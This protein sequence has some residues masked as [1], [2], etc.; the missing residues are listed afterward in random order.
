MNR[1]AIDVVFTWVDSNHP[2]WREEKDYWEKKLLPESGTSKIMESRLYSSFDEIRYGLRSV[3]GYLPWVRHIFLVTNNGSHPQWLN[4][5]DPKITVVD[6][7]T[8][9]PADSLPNYN[10]NAI[11]A[12]LY[13]IPGLSEHFVYFN[14]DLLL[15]KPLQPGHF[16]DL[17]NN[18]LIYPLES[19]FLFKI[20]QRNKF[21]TYL[22][23]KYLK[24]DS[25]VIRPRF[26]TMKE[27]DIPYDGLSTAHCPKILSKSQ[28]RM[29]NRS[30]P[31]QIEQLL[32]TK[33][34]TPT[35]FTYLEA[36]FHYSVKKQET[37]QFT[38]DY[39][40][41]IITILD[42]AIPNSIQIRRTR[43]NLKKYTFL[44]V[45]NAR[46]RI[47]LKEE[48]KFASFLKSLFPSPAPW[49]N[50]PPSPL[51]FAPGQTDFGVTDVIS[52]I[53]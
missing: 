42:Y 51:L 16:I 13:R 28:C 47:N 34:R 53:Q 43:R 44:A 6:Y 45:E 8:L 11:E 32:N 5:D 20:F 3:H 7:R 35:N 33:F 9:L 37:A 38:E 40:T 17:K 39:Q 24:L 14:D 41:R 52:S 30:F 48:R 4:L 22:E 21:L 19:D 46:S 49:E 1:H 15:L 2:E 27:L 10:S 36:L 26:Y 29:F 23:R 50:T 12:F 18:K 25:H 31:K